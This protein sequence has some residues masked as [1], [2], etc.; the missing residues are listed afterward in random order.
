VAQRRFHRK[1]KRT[2]SN[3]NGETVKKSRVALFTGVV[4][5]QR[6]SCEIPAAQNADFFEQIHEKKA[7]I[8]PQVFLFFL[9]SASSKR[10]GADATVKAYVTERHQTPKLQTS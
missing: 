1:H 9:N 3:R 10:R 8:A 7:Q 4:D 6:I 5:L 2:L